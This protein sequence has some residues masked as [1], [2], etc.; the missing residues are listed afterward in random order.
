MLTIRSLHEAP[1]LGL[2]VL[3][4]GGDD[5]LDVPVRW[6]HNTELLDPSGYLREGELVLTNGLWLDTGASGEFVANVARARCAGIVFGLRDETPRTPRQL[7]AACEEEEVP[8]LELG[9]EVPFTAVTREAASQLAGARQQVLVDTVRRG[10]DLAGAISRGAGATGVLQVVRRDHDLPLAVVDRMGRV[11]AQTG[12]ELDAPAARAV[13]EGL[14]RHPPPLRVDL[15]GAGEAMLFLVNTLARADAALVCVSPIEALSEV[16]Q[17]ALTQAA[18]YLSLE[19]ARAELVRAMESRFAQELLEMILSGS[20]RAD[21]VPARLEAF[22]IRPDEPLA[23]LAIAMRG[24]GPAADATLAHAVGEFFVSAGTPSVVVAGSSDVVALF[25]WSESPALLRGR[26]HDLVAEVDDRA[27]AAP[28]VVGL[29]GIAEHSGRLRLPLSQARDA[30]HVLRRSPGDQ[31][32]ARLD[33]LGTHRLLLGTHDV[34]M[35]LRFAQSVL[36]PLREYDAKRGAQL[37]ATV[38]AFLQHDG[39]WADTAAALF[40]HVNTLRNRLAR[41]RDLTGRDVATTVGRVDVFLAL[42]ADRISNDE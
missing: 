2:R 37:E 35:R 28:L 31:R 1:V 18:H 30:C 3:V 38:R 29:G 20:R 17:A 9:I 39:H 7:I 42:E 36:G 40:I 14:H 41:V 32:I 19:V 4:A 33:D 27:V 24:S 10:N 5:A 21:E 12:V 23:V 15:G 8:L 11:L 16:E 22:G 26:A 6:L 25:P 13:A 34:D